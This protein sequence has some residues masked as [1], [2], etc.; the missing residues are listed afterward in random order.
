[1]EVGR[2]PR[3]LSTLG[4][5]GF[6]RKARSTCFEPMRGRRSSSPHANCWIPCVS[7]SIALS[8][9]ML[10]SWS[11]LFRKTATAALP[12]SIR[13]KLTEVH[14]RSALFRHVLFRLVNPSEAGRGRSIINVHKAHVPGTVIW[15]RSFALPAAPNTRR[16][17]SRR[18]NAYLRRRAAV[19]STTRTNLD[20]TRGPNGWTFQLIPPVRAWSDRH[21]NTATICDRPTCASCLHT[22]WKCLV[23]LHCDAGPSD[24]CLDQRAR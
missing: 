2:V 5:A 6:S 11:S 20:H 15:K 3:V 13:Q 21:W 1:P 19:R 4:Q 22:Q 24:H 8:G 10:F 16:A 14:G 23:G 9:V 12:S 17:R 7:A 18:D